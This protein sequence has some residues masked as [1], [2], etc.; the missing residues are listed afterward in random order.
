LE[1]KCTTATAVVLV[2]YSRLLVWWRTAVA[3][4][5]VFQFGGLLC[6][7]SLRL[8][9]GIPTVVDCGD[10]HWLH[11]ESPESVFQNDL[12]CAIEALTD[13]EVEREVASDNR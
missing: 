13:W 9:L 4:T 5:L 2:R 12:E 7:D 1:Y 6:G 3:D 11:E 8:G 10:W